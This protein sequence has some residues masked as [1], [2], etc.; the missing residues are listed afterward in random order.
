MD[1]L[2]TK[3]AI[4]PSTGDAG[5]Y[6]N[7]FVVPKC[8]GCLQPILSLKLFNQYMHIPTYKLPTIRQV[9]Q[10]IQQGNY[11]YCIDPR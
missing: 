4:E 5:F 1:E 2:L 6:S 8:T 9:W 3:C 7:V 11:A 10:L